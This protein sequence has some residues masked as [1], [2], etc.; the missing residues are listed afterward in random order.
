MI[1]QLYQIIIVDDGSNDETLNVAHRYRTE[2]EMVNVL[3]LHK[4]MGKGGAIKQGVGV[5]KGDYVLF[6]SC[7]LQQIRRKV[8]S[9]AYIFFKYFL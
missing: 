2:F 6:V 8:L 3:A 1:P 9:T 4:N 7:W 5:A